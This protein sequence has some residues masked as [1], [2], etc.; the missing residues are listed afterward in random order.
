[1]PI[2]IVFAIISVFIG[3]LPK[4]SR[5]LAHNLCPVFVHQYELGNSQKGVERM[6]RDGKIQL[7]PVDGNSQKGVESN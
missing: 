5:K 6:L 7:P 3:K 2:I 4:G 1:M